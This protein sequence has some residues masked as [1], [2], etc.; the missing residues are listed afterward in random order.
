MNILLTGAT[1]FIGKSLCLTLAEE[2]HHLT[3][4]TR[5][6]KSAQYTI[7]AP[8][9]SVV[10]PTDQALSE[11]DLKLLRQTDAV[12]YLAGESIAGSRWN[13]AVKKRIYD[14]RVKG[15]QDLIQLCSITEVKS[16]KSLDQRLGGWF[17][18]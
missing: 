3:V 5:D 4:L 18:R 6:P 14:S 9:Q 1:G 11:N 8:H 13:K 16:T 2:G 15:T 12:I 17:L 7:P 10:W